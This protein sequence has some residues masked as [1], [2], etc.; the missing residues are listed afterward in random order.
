MK[1]FMHLFLLLAG[2]TACGMAGAAQPDGYPSKPVRI[3]APFSAGGGSDVLARLVA[4]KLS[5][6]MGRSVIVDN[7][8]SSGGII[9]MEVAARA[10]PDG[11]T[12]AML[13]GS[14]AAGS[15]LRKLP[16]DLKRDFAAINQATE[17]PYVL[18]VHPDMPARDIKSLIALAKV[19]PEGIGYGSSGTGSMQ[20]MSGVL[21][22][23]LAKIRLLHIPYKGGSVALNDLLGGHIQMGFFNYIS[24]GPHI[25]NGR[26]RALGVTTEKRSPALPD[27]PAIAEFIPGYDVDNWYGFVG[28]ANLPPAVIGRLSRE[29]SAVLLDPVTK[30]KLAAEAS[31]VVASTPRAFAE[32]IRNDIDRWGKLIAEAGVKLD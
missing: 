26:A 20:H 11:Y 25:R 13:T 16:F 7:R 12:L 29:I 31:E 10:A 32:R 8:P 4:E 23:S 1:Y 15:S 24:A 28:P 27:T 2:A 3:I 21:L 5:A 22:M 17:Q 30:Q 9:G 18:I 14:I 19:K 6:R